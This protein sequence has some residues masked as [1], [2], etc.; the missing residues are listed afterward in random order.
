M[1]YHGVSPRVTVNWSIWTSKFTFVR[2]G[3]SYDPAM[4]HSLLLQHG[5]LDFATSEC[6]L[7]RIPGPI[8][9]DEPRRC[10]Y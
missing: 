1:M 10:R 4:P 7:V 8:E 2:Y 5:A 9:V 3:P 6:I